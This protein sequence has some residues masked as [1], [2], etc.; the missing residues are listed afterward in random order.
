MDRQHKGLKGAREALRR[1]GG[2]SRRDFLKSTA[3]G[4]AGGSLATMLGARTAP[5][6]IRG[7]NLSIIQ[8]SH[9]VP[10]YDAWFDKFATD[11]GQKNGV[12]VRV[13]HI[14]HLDQPARYAAELAA[15][16]GHDLISRTIG[17]V[18]GLYYEHLVDI[19]D[20]ME[21]IGKKYGGWIP[22][23]LPLCQVESRWYGYPDFYILQPMLYRKDLFDA[24]GLEAPDTWEKAR[25]A[26][27][28]LKTKGHPTGSQLSH[29]NDSNHN[30][31]TF[32]Y[33]FGGKET[34]P[35]G[36]EILLDS[37]ETRESLKF[38]KA[39]FD[40]GM[41]PEVYSWDDASDNRYL[42]SGVAGFIHD[43]ISAYLSTKDTNPEV[44]KGIKIGIEPAGSS[45][46]HN[47]SDPVVYSIWKF[48]RNIEAAKDF[49]MYLEDNQ[50]EAM[51]ASRGYNMPFLKD[52]FKKPMPVIGTDPNL[53]VLQEYPN[54]VNFW[55]YPGPTTPA[56]AEVLAT[57]V[58]PDMYARY[59]RTGDLEGT[60]KWAVGEVKRIYAKH[61]MNS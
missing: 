42:A 37:K 58:M 9:F 6:A 60:V 61:G 32:L 11:W 29:C 24:N 2:L 35:T 47:V 40:E 43:A 18:V 13:D 34:D 54:V 55:G 4:V 17:D 8:W 7:T 41:T 23:T 3:V 19:S 46:R 36:K 15:G 5:A 30:C 20:M 31:R 21:G 49:L 59:T 51:T 22:S 39:L 45:G 56:A 38:V 16:A 57:F 50:K 26:A 48:S 28:L 27:R 44:F 14:P 33:A 10:A 25:A 1:A 53:E 12:S 52:Q